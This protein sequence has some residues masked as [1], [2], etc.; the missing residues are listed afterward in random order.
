MTILTVCGTKGGVG[1]TTLCANLAG[2]VSDW[3]WNVLLIDTDPQPSLSRYFPITGHAKYGVSRLFSHLDVDES[4]SKTALPRLD[5]IV[6][7]DPGL[8]CESLLHRIPDGRNRVKSAL[9]KLAGYDFVII[10]TKGSVNPMLDAALIASDRVLCPIVPDMLSSREF[11]RGTL[12]SICKLRQTFATSHHS[13]SGVLYRTRRTID[14]YK[15]TRNIHSLFENSPELRI[16]ATAVPDRIVYKDAATAQV[17]VHLL[18]KNRRLGAS[19]NETMT[20]L[21]LELWPMLRD[22]TAQIKSTS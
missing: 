21:A 5:I 10:D 6:S 11:I 8:E 17:P 9:Q 18:E 20:S 7:D 13:V 12:Q 16:L 22:S 14:G 15:V 3:G 1:K 4:I 2:L 19:A